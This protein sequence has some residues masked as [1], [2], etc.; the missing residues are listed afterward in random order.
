MSC[1]VTFKMCFL[2]NILQICLSYAG[3]A[4]LIG[5][6][7]YN[8][9]LVGFASPEGSFS[10]Q[11]LK[12]DH[13]PGD[14]GFDPLGLK[15]DD[16]VEFATMQTKELQN[17]RLAMLGAAGIMAQELVNGEEIFVNLGLATDSFDPSSVPIQ[18]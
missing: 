12:E 11:Q 17:G 6:L 5:S 1:F 2:K 18:F 4:L 8:R 9:A 3:L 10:F 7:E 16:P 15:P 13:Y 14:I